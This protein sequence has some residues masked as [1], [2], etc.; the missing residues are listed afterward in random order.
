VTAP[1]SGLVAV[2]FTDLVGSTELMSRLGDR[3]FDELRRRHFSA[4][5]NAVAAHGGEEVKNT[6]DGLM[7]VFPSAADAVEAAVAMQQAA[8]RQAR[9]TPVTIRVG[10]AVGDAT[11]EDGDYF[12]TPVVEAARLVAAAEPG[13]ILTTQIARALAGA[14]CSA[15]FIDRGLLEL[16]GLPEPVAVCEVCWQP[17]G[18]SVP[19]PALL[20]GVGRIFVGRDAEL[21]RLGQLWKEAVAGERR[22][23][24]LAGEP[25]A[26]KTRLAAEMASRAHDE[27]GAVLAGRCDED[28]GVPYQPFVEAL[29]HFVDHTAPAE[30]GERLGRYGGELTRLRPEL[31]ELVPGLPT[32]L[33]SDP[34]TE[35]YR[36]FDAVAA[37]LGAVSAEKPVLLALDDL[38]WAAKPTLLLVR[39]VLRFPDPLRLLV[40]VTYR[41]TDI[42]RGHPL[43]ELLAD[44]RRDGGVERFSVGGLD[45]A[46]VG[47]FMEAAAGHPL[48]DQEGEAFVGAVWEE[49]EGN[50]FFVTEVVR[51]LSE[52]GRI[53]RR[54]GRWV[55][56]VPVEDLGIPE[57]VRDVVG[58]RLSRLSDEVNE[59]LRVASVV[60]AEFDS[61]VVGVAGR[62]GEDVVA[63]A[64]ERAVAARLLAEVP[65]VAGRYRFPH[66]LVRG[67]LYDEVTTARRVLMHRHVA[68]AIEAIHAERIDD[69]LSAL[70]HHW[71]RASAPAADT[72]RAVAYATRAGDRALAQ[73]AHDEAVAYYV[74]ALQLLDASAQGDGE[75]TRLDLLIRLGDAQRRAGDP[76]HRQT[77]LDAAHLAQARHDPVGLTRAALAN[78]RGILW[79]AGGVVDTERVAVLEAAL[80][81]TSAESSE[82]RARLLANLSLELVFAKDPQRCRELSDTALSV[83]R[84]LNDPSTLAHVLIARYY[85]VANPATLDHR[86]TDTAELLAV[87]VSLQDPLAVLRAWQLRFRAA[88]ESGDGAEA[89]RCLAAQEELTAQLHQP[90]PRWLT[91]VNRTGRALCLGRIDEA[92]RLA[93][94]TYELGRTGGQADALL[95]YEVFHRY[96]ILLEADRL[97]ELEERFRD[98]ARRFSHLPLLHAMLARLYGELDRPADAEEVFGQLAHEGFDAFPF[99]V[100]WS[101]AITDAAA[102][103]AYLGDRPRAAVLHDLLAAVPEQVVL[104][105]SGVITGSFSHYLGM[106]ATVLG[107]FDEAQARFEAAAQT[108]LRL[109]SPAWLARTRLEWARMLLTRR[110]PGDTERARELLGQALGSAREFG[111]ANVERRTVELLR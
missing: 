92:E 55:S 23:V 18:S 89:D 105:A 2:L 68:E 79:A 78:S 63:S 57:G 36:L 22:V 44:L 65:G 3:A 58:R 24:F 107:R 101:R 110:A 50:P 104:I 94:D 42:G 93:A 71:A 45:R 47:E 16:K 74:Q 40:V 82:A 26:G 67:T 66:T 88:M 84:R 35:R 10:V 12:G 43:T 83:A 1:R 109:G 75:A 33:R 91:L 5:A 6:G 51:H 19:M 14:R 34:E 97:G 21:E 77:L 7:A 62:F 56:T 76:A 30:L 52:T 70:A 81:A 90:E 8:A 13:K 53:E 72:A 103:C 29:R 31:A 38:H 85:A 37:W 96:A 32:P 106:L 4:L 108:Q 20:T 27:G 25:G 64:L 17:A 73:L 54:D 95:Y 39:H 111:L 87:A 69:H 48:A 98:W 9:A 28:L 86:L 46:A 100:T 59:V 99:D 49:T 41:D 61:G 11:F 60:G 15:T 80:E 102:V